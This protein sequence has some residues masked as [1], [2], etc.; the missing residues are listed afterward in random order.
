M[1][2]MRFQLAASCVRAQTSGSHKCK[3]PVQVLHAPFTA[4]AMKGRSSSNERVDA[5]TTDQ[6]IIQYPHLYLKSTNDLPPILS[7]HSLNWSKK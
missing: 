6:I 3:T 2:L 4:V 5:T 7:A 1:L